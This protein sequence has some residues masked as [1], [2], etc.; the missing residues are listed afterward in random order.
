MI[1][2]FRRAEQSQSWSPCSALFL[3]WCYI[4]L[5]LSWYYISL[6]YWKITMKNPKRYL[7]YVG[8][9]LIWINLTNFSEKICENNLK[10][11]LLDLPSFKKFLLFLFVMCSKKIHFWVD[12]NILVQNYSRYKSW[13][14]ATRIIVFEWLLRT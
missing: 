13:S 7:K 1:F 6:T 9:I 5:F 11:K 3:S 14:A 10:I 8:K 4:N 12:H 2:C